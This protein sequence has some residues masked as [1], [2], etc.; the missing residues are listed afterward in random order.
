MFHTYLKIASEEL[1]NPEET[2]L[3]FSRMIFNECNHNRGTL[4]QIMH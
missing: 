3:P 2:I 1:N 4:M